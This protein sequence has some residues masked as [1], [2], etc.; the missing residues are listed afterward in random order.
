MA[1]K[2]KRLRKILTKLGLKGKLKSVTTLEEAHLIC[3]ENRQC[4]CKSIFTGKDTY[5]QKIEEGYT[6]PEDQV[7]YLIS[8]NPRNV[9]NIEQ[10]FTSNSFGVLKIDLHS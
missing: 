8:P 7:H 3:I 10:Q 6:F 9:R 2:E 5:R 1:D 4:S